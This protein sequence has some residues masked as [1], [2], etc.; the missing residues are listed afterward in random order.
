M[1]DINVHANC[2]HDTFLSLEKLKMSFEF[3]RLILPLK[4]KYVWGWCEVTV[5][6][7]CLKWSGALQFHNYYQKE[8]KIRNRFI[9]QFYKNGLVYLMVNSSK[10]SICFSWFNSAKMP[11]SNLVSPVLINM[12]QNHLL[13]NTM[14]EQLSSYCKNS[15]VA[16]EKHRFVLCDFVLRKTNWKYV[17]SLLYTFF[18]LLLNN[19]FLN[20]F[21][22]SIATLTTNFNQ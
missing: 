5:G 8:L 3:A 18:Y 10:I 15:L 2:K 4:N 22:S 1:E 9:T 6:G 21:N 14:D 19:W 13:P 12:L 20:Y 16:W 7:F 17:L 11:C